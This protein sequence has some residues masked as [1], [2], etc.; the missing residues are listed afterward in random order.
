MLNKV[1]FYFQDFKETS[2]LYTVTSAGLVHS[3]AR[4]C[5]LGELESCTCDNTLETRRTKEAWLA[6]SCGDNVRAALNLAGRFQYSTYSPNQVLSQHSH[7]V[8]FQH[9]LHR[10]NFDVGFRVSTHMYTEC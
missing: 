10:H 1:I 2:F 9:A 4:A 8:Q 3:L 7:H 6:G 5:S